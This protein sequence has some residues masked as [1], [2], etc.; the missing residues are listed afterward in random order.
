MDK[1]TEEIIRKITSQIKGMEDVDIEEL[2]FF[3]SSL[4]NLQEQHRS[5]S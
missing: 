5:T 3:I 2:Y 1:Q 4:S